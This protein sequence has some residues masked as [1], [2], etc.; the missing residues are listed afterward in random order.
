MM[1]E[2]VGF[3]SSFFCLFVRN[4][5]GRESL[6]DVGNFWIFSFLFLPFS[7]K[8]EGG[9]SFDDDGNCWIFLFFFLSSCSKY[10]GE[11]VLG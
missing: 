1:L 3:S 11:G 4:M 7:S 8:Y 2:I 5:R 6:D 10:E 9:E